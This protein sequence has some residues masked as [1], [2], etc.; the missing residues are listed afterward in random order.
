MRDGREIELKLGL[1]PDDMARLSSHPPLA[2]PAQAPPVRRSLASVY[3]DTPDFALA[4]A[5]VALRVRSTGDGLVQT[6]K[7]PGA[8]GAGLFDRPEWET[9]LPG[10]EPA[11]DRDHLRAT[12]LALFADP[13]L[14]ARLRPMFSTEIHRT[15]YRLGGGAEPDGEAW[16]VEAAL[17]HGR[18]VAGERSEPICEVEF[19][20][21]RGEPHRLFDLARQMLAAVPVRPLSLSK[22]ERGVRLAS[23]DGLRP[24]KARVPALEPRLG[25]GEAFQTIARSCLD[26]LLVNEHCLLAT[27]DGEAIHQMRVA[28]RRLR[29]AIRLFRPVVEGP[30]LAEIGAELRWLLERLGP[31]RD[32]EVLRAEILA[33]VRAARPDDDG[34]AA[35]DAAA[36]RDLASRLD[37]AVAAVRDRRFAALVLDLGAWIESGEWRAQ[38]TARLAAPIPPFARHRLAK[39]TRRLLRQGGEDLLA[40]TPPERHEVRIRAKQARYAAEFFAALLPRKA[41]AGFIEDLA[42]LQDALGRLNDL[43]VALPRLAALPDPGAV[44]AAARVAAWHR[45]D[46]AELLAEAARGWRRLRQREMPW[47]ER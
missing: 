4:R 15:T 43:A 14:L 41:V 40:L 21:V 10:A 11:L 34:L 35:L 39:I 9:A 18:V 25:V 3:F 42:A 44:A 12:G 22:S 32:A 37:I 1:A 5:G 45:A 47:A 17:D 8:G 29:S 7:A 16:E 36:G 20:L 28:L 19:E 13:A 30:R 2:L 23:G 6:V 24:V 33:P 26:H 31:A 38:R 46:E 27:G